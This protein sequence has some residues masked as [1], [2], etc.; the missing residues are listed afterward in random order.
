MNTLVF[1]I[2]DLA[3]SSKQ[4]LQT[5]SQDETAYVIYHACGASATVHGSSFVAIWQSAY[6]R[7]AVCERRSPARARRAPL[8]A[9]CSIR[10][11]PNTSRLIVRNLEDVETDEERV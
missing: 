9:A 8:L 5:R 1:P 4:A 11:P 3:I 6:W 2:A 7:E 10:V